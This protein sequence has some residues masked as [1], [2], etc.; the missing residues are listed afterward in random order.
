MTHVEIDDS[1]YER[2]SNLVRNG[3]R[4]IAEGL[5]F[6][7]DGKL[8]EGHVALALAHRKM[9]SVNFDVNHLGVH[10]THRVTGGIGT[11]PYKMVE[12][13]EK[14]IAILEARV[15][16]LENRTGIDIPITALAAAAVRLSKEALKK[17][18]LPQAIAYVVKESGPHGLTK[19]E[20]FAKISWKDE[21]NVG[22]RFYE[23]Q[24]DSRIFKV[25]NR[26]VHISFKDSHPEAFKAAETERLERAYGFDK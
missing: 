24:R 14:K 15:V 11:A 3:L 21:E 6:S 13:K 12:M 9:Q 10:D 25:G 16:E 2:I 5:N 1:D 17:L 20:V 23:A 26:Y 22:K 7:D 8:N 18:P 4:N 19:D